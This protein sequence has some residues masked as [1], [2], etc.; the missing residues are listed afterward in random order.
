MVEVKLSTQLAQARRNKRLTAATLATRTGFDTSGIYAI[1]HGRRDARESTLEAIAG[2]LGGQLILV[3]TDNR[4]TVADAAEEIRHE[5]TTG[6]VHGA[7]QVLV[8]VFADLTALP[9][10]PTLTLAHQPPVPVD[11]RWDAALAGVV[12]LALQKS[13]L[14]APAWTEQVTRTTDIPWDPWTNG[15]QPLIGQDVPE[16]LLRRGVFI[17]EAELAS[18]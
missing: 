1:E 8:Q 12:E 13:G 14:P 3:D 10:L 11:E 7:A 17:A 16:P 2:A 4:G 9:A 5:L 18:A 15:A 6:N